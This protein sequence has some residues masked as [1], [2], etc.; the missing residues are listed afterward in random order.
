M[1]PFRSLAMQV[2]IVPI[3]RWKERDKRLR[4]FGE[5]ASAGKKCI[6]HVCMYVCVCEVRLSTYIRIC[7]YMHIFIFIFFCLYIL[8][9]S[10]NICPNTSPEFLF[11]H[12]LPAQFLHIYIDRAAAMNTI[13][14]C[15][16]PMSGSEYKKFEIIFSVAF[17]L[18]GDPHPHVRA[19]A[20]LFI[21]DVIK[22]ATDECKSSI[23]GLLTAS[24]S[25]VRE[26]T[27]HE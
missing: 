24:G 4:I 10:A 22:S 23:V 8:C 9:V 11:Y 6:C 13:R 18:I 14:A 15:K 16:E 2:T 21:K 26:P 25:E 5:I 20:C 17:G 19:A 12:H 3:R 1:A 27:A 7:P